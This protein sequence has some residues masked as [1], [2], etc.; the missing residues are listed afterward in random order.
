[1]ARSGCAAS[2]P[3]VH[4]C[5]SFAGCLG[6]DCDENAMILLQRKHRSL[7][8]SPRSCLSSQQ[9]AQNQFRRVSISAC[10]KVG[11]PKNPRSHCLGTHPPNSE[12]LMTLNHSRKYC[13][14]WVDWSRGELAAN[15]MRVINTLLQCCSMMGRYGK[16]VFDRVC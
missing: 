5:R 10:P 14:L 12:M 2:C 3:T 7:S 1:M 6:K 13:V 4:A 9:Q 15:R 11:N 16:N 8:V